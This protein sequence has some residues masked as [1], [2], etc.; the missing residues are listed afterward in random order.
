M[1]GPATESRC[2]VVVSALKPRRA[3]ARVS[4]AVMADN[5]VAVVG[6]FGVGCAV[7]APD[8]AGVGCAVGTGVGAGVGPV[9]DCVKPSDWL[10]LVL[11]SPL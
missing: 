7:G 11:E 8:G 5:A 1:P 2:V 3:S 9:T 10:G 4:V 6:G